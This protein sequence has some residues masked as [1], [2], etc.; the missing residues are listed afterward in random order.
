MTAKGKIGELIT[1]L[2]VKTEFP[3]SKSKGTAPNVAAVTDTDGRASPA[4]LASYYFFQLNSQPR[5][6]EDVLASVLAES[7][8]NTSHVCSTHMIWKP[9]F[10]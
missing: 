3:P 6:L 1:F 9:S 5:V 8:S 10:L 2:F 4:L 7:S